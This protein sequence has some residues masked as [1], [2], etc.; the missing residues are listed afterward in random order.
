MPAL[1]DISMP[2]ENN[3]VSWP[4]DPG[5][6]IRSVL[7]TADGDPA[8]VSHLSL[9][10]HTGTHVDAFSHFQTG[11]TPM[12]Q[13]DLNIYIG[14]ARVVE[15]A[16]PAL[17]TV[18]EL[19]E[20]DWTQ[21]QRVLFKTQN[22]KKYWLHEPFNENFVHL[23]P[24]SAEFLIEQK[25]QLVGIDYLSVEGFHIENAP[26]HHRLMEA[27]VYIVEGLYL[28]DVQPGWYELICL[29]LKITNGDGAP[30]RVVLRELQEQT[31]GS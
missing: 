30:A 27:Q 16:H 22:S 23:T 26:S 7:N 8:S 13:M 11:G 2:I 10:S 28:K 19:K 14:T 1:Y 29:P 31:N 20:T 5:V 25:V 3:M 18:E 12:D 15:I 24:E 21:V 4:G 9:G 6:E 17:I